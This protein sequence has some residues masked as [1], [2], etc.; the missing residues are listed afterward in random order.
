MHTNDTLISVMVLLLFA[1]LCVGVFYLKNLSDTLKC[2]SPVNRRMAPG[3]VWLNLIPI[4]SYVW[5]FITVVKMSESLTNEFYRRQLHPIHYGD[6]G[7][8]IGIAAY[9]LAILSFVPFIGGL[10]ALAALICWIVYWVKIAKYKNI[11]ER[12]ILLQDHGQSKTSIPASYTEPGWRP[13]E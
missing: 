6:F 2:V 1:T 4:L 7:Q 12:S 5:G 13:E 11:L 8:K 9:A 10:C 3:L